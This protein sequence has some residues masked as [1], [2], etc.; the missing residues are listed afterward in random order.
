MVVVVVVVVVFVSSSTLINV[1]LSTFSHCLNWI[2][3]ISN[4]FGDFISYKISSFNTITLSLGNSFLKSK[5]GSTYLF[6]A[7]LGKFVLSQPYV[8][9]INMKTYI[10]ANFPSSQ[11]LTVAIKLPYMC[12]IFGIY[13]WRIWGNTKKHISGVCTFYLVIFLTIS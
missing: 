11:D 4:F 8:R 9:W 6:E 12:H 3:H 1:D 10:S 5:Q 2:D 7:L 13:T